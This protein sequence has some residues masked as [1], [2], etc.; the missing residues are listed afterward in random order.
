MRLIYARCNPLTNSTDA[1]TFEKYIVRIEC[2][3]AEDGL[4]TA[5]CSQSA[6]NVL[7]VDDP[8]EYARP[9]FDRE[10][11]VRADAIYMLIIW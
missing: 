3:K 6:L 9:V 11:R 8:P 5:P 1:A 4:Q 2:N 10:M 7:E